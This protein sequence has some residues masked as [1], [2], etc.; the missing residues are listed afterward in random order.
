MTNRQ[1]YFLLLKKNNRFLNERVIKNLLLYLNNFE[2]DLNLFAHFDDEVQNSNKI[3]RFVKQLCDGFPIQYLTGRAHFFS[4]NYYV[5]QDVLIPRPE[6]EELVIK[7]IDLIK[8]IFKGSNKLKIIDI[9]TGSGVIADSLKRT[10]TDADVVGIDVSESAL[11]VAKFN[12][13]GKVQLKMMDICV[14]GLIVGQICGRWG[15]FFNGEAYGPVVSRSFLEGLYLPNFIIDGM[16]IN[17]A[18]HHPTF[19]YESLWNFVGF[20]LLLLFRR[21]SYIKEGQLTGFYLMWY[22]L[23]RF[24]IESLRTDSL[25]FG[26]LKVAQLVSIFMFLFGFFLIIFRMR[27]SKFDFLYNKEEKNEI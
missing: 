5:N 15:N 27:S 26:D 10:F 2:N 17:G 11:K 25:M 3:D 4:K 6:T 18:Y 9:G 19:L 23:G 7:S 8:H 13:N 16:Y 12:T 1:L 22:S 14:V 20:L 21:F 24:Y